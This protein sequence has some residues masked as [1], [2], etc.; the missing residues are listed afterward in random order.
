MINVG[1]VME[2]YKNEV[3]VMTV[4]FELVRVKRNPEVYL[5]QQ[6]RFR[7]SD[8]IRPEIRKMKFLLASGAAAV[9]MVALVAIYI[10]QNISLSPENTAYAFIDMDVNP[11]IGFLIDNTNTV[12]KV[13]PLNSD[14]ENL[15][16]VLPLKNLPVKEAIKKIIDRS[17]ETGILNTNKNN[18]IMISASLNPENSN[19]K[20]R[21][22]NAQL[23]LDQLLTSLKA[24][25]D[26]E[27]NNKYNI[28]VVQVEP[29]IKKQA[30]ENGLSA[31][32]QLIFKK[33]QTEGIDLTLDEA[34]SGNMSTLME[35]VGID[36]QTTDKEPLS[37]PVPQYSEQVTVSAKPISEKES[38]APVKMSTPTPASSSNSIVPTPTKTPNASASIMP[39]ATKT[40]D[41]PA[42]ILPTAT[43]TPDVSAS[44][45]PTA[46][47]TPDSSADSIKIQYYNV[48]K[49]VSDVI[50]INAVFKIINTGNT[51]INLKDVTIRYYY[52]I[53]GEI[54]QLLDCWAQEGKP[55]ITYSFVKMSEPVEK[56]DYYLEIGFKSGQLNPGK[57]T[58][59]V[60]WFNKDD[61]SSYKQDDDFSY[62]SSNIQEYY[63]WNYVPGYISGI[64]KWGTEPGN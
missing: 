14:A 36:E 42:S 46:A 7:K 34:K 54:P 20:D 40:P 58:E 27:L 45:L 15:T 61:W 18:V 16:K 39:A 33:A 6:V 43:K 12:Q 32:R 37:S 4:D 57:G 62:N 51:T 63:D 52:T 30:L 41:V 56:A 1:T 25:D 17:K 60:V 13:L 28:K 2:I 10:I 55:N 35:K 64:L 22:D 26:A 5:G 31:G 24:I 50:Q 44:I 29:E 49:E 21:K 3:L 9:L 48:S 19:Y 59:V 11:S 53:N 23:K 8:I 38:A 47:K